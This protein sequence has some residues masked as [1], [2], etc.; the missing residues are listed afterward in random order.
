VQIASLLTSKSQRKSS[1]KT[2]YNKDDQGP[3]ALPMP[4]NQA[5]EAYADKANVAVT[6][7]R[8]SAAESMPKTVSVDPNEV[9]SVRE[10][11][12]S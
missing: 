10:S 3:D 6:Q 5:A 9:D 8:S 2:V 4:D 11:F 7:A 1:P 12:P